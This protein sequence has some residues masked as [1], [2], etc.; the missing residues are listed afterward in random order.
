MRGGGGRANQ[1]SAEFVSDDCAVQQPGSQPRG[2]P[3]LLPCLLPSPFCCGQPDRSCRRLRLQPPGGFILAKWI[4]LL[5]RVFLPASTLPRTGLALPSNLQALQ[6]PSPGQCGPRGGADG[7]GV[8]LEALVAWPPDSPVQPLVNATHAWPLSGG[9]ACPSPASSEDSG[10]RKRG[11]PPCSSPVTLRPP[12]SSAS[13]ARTRQAASG[14]S[15]PGLA[16]PSSLLRPRPA[17]ASTKVYIPGPAPQP[18]PGPQDP[19]GREAASP[20]AWRRAPPPRPASQQPDQMPQ[21]F[22]L[23]QR[24]LHFRAASGASRGV[25]ST[26]GTQ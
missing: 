4:W 13:V 20:S 25:P 22:G 15:Q 1:R 14:C 5:L 10:P 18:P 7:V 9:W 17:S 11:A 12:W 16:P 8:D 26:P 19:R 24:R 23:S 6:R 2:D 21:P 3:S